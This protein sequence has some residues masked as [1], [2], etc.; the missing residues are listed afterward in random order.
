MTKKYKVVVAGAGPGGCIFARDLARKGFEVVVYEKGKY[1]TMGHDWSDAVERRGLAEAGFEL[2]PE[3]TLNMGPLVKMPGSDETPGQ[4]FEPHAYP[5]MEVWAPDYSCKKMIKFNYIT[6]DRRKL[7]KVLVDQAREAGAVIQFG[8]EVVDILQSGGTSLE[9]AMVKGVKVKNLES[10]EVSDVSADVVAD[11]TGFAALLRTRLPDATGM[12]SPFREE[13][14]ANVHRTVRKRRKDVDDTIMDHY[15]YG[16]H[17]GYQ[18]VQYLNDDQ[19][20]TGAG[21]RA[22]PSNPD[23]KDIVEEFISRHPSISD[24][25]VRGGGGRCLVG[26]SPYSLV[27]GGF[28]VIGD[29]ASQTITMT[30]CG[31]GGAM[32]GGR[33]AAEVVARAAQEGRND[34]AALWPYNWKWF[35]ESGRGAHY[36]ALN[37]LRNIVQDLSHDDISFLFRKDILNGEM[38][39]ASINGTFMLPDLKTMA[40]TLARGISRPGLLLKLNKATTVGTKILKHYL[41]YPES[42]N[43]AA[44]DAWRT[45]TDDLFGK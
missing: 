2:P 40:L 17:T 42:W 28:V 4:I 36:A 27:A 22:D 15:R 6:T 3:S 45:R 26:K 1:E 10:R 32:A 29:A 11:D 20:D 23:P 7:G 30:G 21:V 16:Y 33:L 5:D 13:E 34:I 14:F 9:D 12:A 38:L 24:E 25:V 8:H 35:V 18:W 37:A 41:K 43:P 31:A 44:F 19:I 39:T